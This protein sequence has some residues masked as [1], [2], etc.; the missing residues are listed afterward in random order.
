[1][2][3][4][5]HG[6]EICSDTSGGFIECICCRKLVCEKCSRESLVSGEMICKECAEGEEEYL[7]E[8]G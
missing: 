5:V 6:C 7:G 1:M 2:K 3:C 4:R 8:E